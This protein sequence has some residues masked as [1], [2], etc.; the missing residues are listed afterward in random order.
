MN[1]SACHVKSFTFQS[2]E[3]TLTFERFNIRYYETIGQIQTMAVVLYT[4]SPSLSELLMSEKQVCL[5]ISL[6]SSDKF[7]FDPIQIPD[8]HQAKQSRRIRCVRK[9]PLN[10]L[11]HHFRLALICGDNV[12]LHFQDG[13]RGMKTPDFSLVFFLWNFFLL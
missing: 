3:N 7:H 4:S 5:S 11:L 1:V 10:V 9:L 6:R 13:I 12:M 8:E 2:A